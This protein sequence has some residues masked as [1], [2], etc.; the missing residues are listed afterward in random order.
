MRV[1]RGLIPDRYL[2]L[3]L[4]AIPFLTALFIAHVRPDLSKV[5]YVTGFVGAGIEAVSEIWYLRDYWN[6]PSLLPCPHQKTCSTALA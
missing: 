2:Y 1:V 4:G 6:P 3:T 5:V